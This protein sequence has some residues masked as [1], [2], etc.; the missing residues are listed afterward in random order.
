VAALE[1]P[2]KG[3][4]VLV[5][6]TAEGPSPLDARLGRPMVNVFLPS[7]PNPTTGFFIMVPRE[8]LLYLDLTV[9][10]AVKLILSGGARLAGRDALQQHLPEM[11]SEPGA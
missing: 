4:Y 9:E 8:Q 5:F 3:L 6:V 1:Y 11:S 10:Q 2:R 7:T